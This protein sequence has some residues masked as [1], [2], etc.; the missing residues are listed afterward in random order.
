MGWCQRPG[1]AMVVF[2]DVSK[3]SFCWAVIS[4]VK[5]VA[6]LEKYINRCNFIISSSYDLIMYLRLL[7][8]Q[9]IK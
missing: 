8:C 1:G 9:R 2:H 6:N 7:Y 3:H 4:L 5:K